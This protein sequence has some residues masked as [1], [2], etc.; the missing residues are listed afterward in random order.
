MSE[1]MQFVM[2]AAGTFLLALLMFYVAGL[3]RNAQ[4]ARLEADRARSRRD[5]IAAAAE[6]LGAAIKAMGGRP[7]EEVVELL[8][9]VLAHLTKTATVAPEGLAEFR[10]LVERNVAAMRT[11]PSPSPEVSARVAM[12][13]QF[14][15]AMEEREEQ[16]HTIG[17]DEY[18][19]WLKIA[20]GAVTVP[21]DRATERAP[22]NGAPEAPAVTPTS[23]A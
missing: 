17:A 11:P 23:A 22:A 8:T 2:A 12:M 15:L 16:G 21:V 1:D 13:Q 18:E 7:S 19:R 3:L 20:V 4:A 14:R 10:E 6:L 9:R 5:D